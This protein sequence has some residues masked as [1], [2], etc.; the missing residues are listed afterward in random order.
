MAM[1]PSLLLFLP[2]VLPFFFAMML[3]AVLWFSKEVIHHFLFLA[4]HISSTLLEGSPFFI[5]EKIVILFVKRLVELLDFLLLEMT[6]HLRN[7]PKHFLFI[8][9]VDEVN[10]II[11]VIK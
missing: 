2:M 10:D 1:S 3:S 8:E 11:S 7:D 5:R 9:E 6:G 4:F